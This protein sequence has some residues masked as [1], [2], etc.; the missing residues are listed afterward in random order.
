MILVIKLGSSKRQSYSTFD[1]RRYFRVVI[2][3]ETA[4]FYPYLRVFSQRSTLIMFII[5]I[6]IIIIIGLHSTGSD[7]IIYN[8]AIAEVSVNE[9]ILFYF[10]IRRGPLRCAARIHEQYNNNII[11]FYRTKANIISFRPHRNAIHLRY[12]SVKYIIRYFNIIIYNY[13]AKRKYLQ[14]TLLQHDS[15]NNYCA[16]VSNVRR[17]KRPAMQVTVIFQF[18]IFIFVCYDYICTL[19]AAG[20]DMNS[21]NLIV[22]NNRNNSVSEE[23]K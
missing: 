15:A 16:M 5:I 6:I 14:P 18:L 7:T 20:F 13:I 22:G 21:M 2:R 11:R 12:S 8:D 1:L 19:N 9:G 23:A 10:L 3:R 17:N 4:N